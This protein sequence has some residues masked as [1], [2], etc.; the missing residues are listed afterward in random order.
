MTE[1]VIGTCSNCGGDV[2]THSGPWLGVVPPS[3][4]C[5]RCGATQAKGPV[6]QMGPPANQRPDPFG[7][8]LRDG[9]PNG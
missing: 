2:V 6:I 7:G 4:R 9:R 8:A 3:L 5:S 1:Q